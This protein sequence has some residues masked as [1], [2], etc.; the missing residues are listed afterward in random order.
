MKVCQ[1]IRFQGKTFYKL[2]TY[3]AC[4][5]VRKIRRRAHI[6]FIPLNQQNVQPCPSHLTSIG[7]C[8]VIYFYSKTN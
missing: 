8:I 7:P 3:I 6:I 5:Y 2:E 4:D 1:E